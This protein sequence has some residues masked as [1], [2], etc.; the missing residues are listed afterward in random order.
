ML[1]T[2]RGLAEGV[3]DPDGATLA[4]RAALSSQNVARLIVRS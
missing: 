1:R 4:R 2:S 3:L